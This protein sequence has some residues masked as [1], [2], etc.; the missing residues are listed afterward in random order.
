MRQHISFLFSNSAG[1]GSGSLHI[2]I[3]LFYFFLFFLTLYLF[4]SPETDVTTSPVRHQTTLFPVVGLRLISDTAKSTISHSKLFRSDYTRCSDL[5]KLGASIDDPYDLILRPKNK[6][7][8]CDSK[9]K[10]LKH[11]LLRKYNGGP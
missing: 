11:K 7:T 3:S 8:G 4:S 9:H 5:R 10:L 2:I 1:S 6:N